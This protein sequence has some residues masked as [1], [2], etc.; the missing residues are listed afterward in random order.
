MGANRDGVEQGSGNTAAS[1]VQGDVEEWPRPVSDDL[2]Q[3]AARRSQGYQSVGSMVY[4]ILREA[5]VDGTLKP[6]QKLRHELLVET[7]GVSRIP[8]RSA[9][10]QL[11]ADGLVELRDRRGA[12]VKALTPAQVREIYDIRIVL[13]TH[14]LR[15]SMA[16]MSAERVELLRRLAQGVDTEKEGGGFV[17][18]RSEFYAALYDAAHQPTLWN[19]IEHLRLKV[20]RYL[21][22]WRLVD[23]SG[24]PHEDLLSAVTRGDIDGA[25]AGLS[26]HLEKV[27]DK[28]LHRL[29]EE[30]A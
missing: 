20:G 4:G 24:H 22:G 15:L 21:L 11:E 14:A 19:M 26:H 2:Q 16:T 30:Y 9:L 18:A 6:G 25:V 7:I 29:E 28:V 27:R 1:P 8:V 13:E 3:L 5:I 17:D 10:I 12:V 23:G